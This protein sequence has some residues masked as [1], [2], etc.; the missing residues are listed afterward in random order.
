MASCPPRDRGALNWQKREF[1]PLDR[2]VQRRQFSQMIA[3]SLPCSVSGAIGLLST[4]CQARTRASSGRDAVGEAYDA[5]PGVIRGLGELTNAGPKAAD[6]RA[7]PIRHALPTYQVH[8]MPEIVKSLVR[9]VAAASS[10]RDQ[11]SR[12]RRH[13]TDQVRLA[14]IADIETCPGRVSMIPGQTAFT[15]MLDCA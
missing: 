3:W 4:D 9:R 7:R 6:L 1:R 13:R 11:R 5:A 8:L 2:P 14:P 10:S 12:A 15:R